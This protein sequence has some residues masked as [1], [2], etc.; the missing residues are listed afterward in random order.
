V[1]VSFEPIEV[2]PP[3]GEEATWEAGE[4][5]DTEVPPIQIGRVSLFAS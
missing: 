5:R 4:R 2:L 3:P 1:T